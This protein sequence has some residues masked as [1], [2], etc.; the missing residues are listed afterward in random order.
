MTIPSGIIKIKT[1]P[2][3][4]LLE[5]AQEVPL[6]NEDGADNHMLLRFANGMMRE[7]L[8]ESTGIALAAPQVG[9]ELCLVV[10]NVLKLNKFSEEDFFGYSDRIM[11]NP[12]ILNKGSIRS[13]SLEGCLSFPGVQQKVTRAEECEVKFIN[14]E[15]VERTVQL[16]GFP[17]RVIQHEV[18]HLRGIT[19]GNYMSDWKHRRERRKLLETWTIQDQLDAA[20]C[21]GSLLD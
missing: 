14:A 12:V 16:K 1:Y 15:M 19:L 5:R 17:A 4:T 8:G 13:S 21:M 9:V 2:F 7:L 11:I 18:D 3:P 20:E 6:G 10:V